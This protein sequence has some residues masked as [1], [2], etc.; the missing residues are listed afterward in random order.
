MHF[1]HIICKTEYLGCLTTFKDVLKLS[2]RLFE[3]KN[4]NDF[5]TNALAILLLPS[6]C[7]SLNCLL[8]RH[9]NLSHFQDFVA[10][11]SFLE[12][13]EAHKQPLAFGHKNV[14]LSALPSG[15][16]LS[17]VDTVFGL[18]GKKTEATL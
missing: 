18:D 8:I 2:M 9:F 6:P 5:I 1:Y 16:K 7:L 4:L 11:S 14:V 3:T 12:T 17:P 13:L 15:G 10:Y